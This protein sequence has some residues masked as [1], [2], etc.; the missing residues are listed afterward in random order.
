MEQ[1]AMESITHVYQLYS[2]ETG[3]MQ[4]EALKLLQQVVA[5]LLKQSV[6]RIG[7]IREVAIRSMIHLFSTTSKSLLEGVGMLS[8]SIPVTYAMSNF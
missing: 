6:E 1:A 3:V 7:R 8:P 4:E 2:I 5:V